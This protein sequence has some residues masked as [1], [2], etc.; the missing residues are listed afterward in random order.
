MF[1]DLF[2]RLRA[3]F[4]RRAVESDLDRELRF[5]I[6]C[7]TEKYIQAGM[8][9]EEAARRA[10]LD[11]GGAEQMKEECRSARGVAL[12]ETSMQDLTYGFRQ[13]RRNPGF[14]LIAVA[15]IALGIAAN[16]AVFSVMNAVLFAKPPYSDPDRLLTVWQSYPA[17][18]EVRGGASAAEYL[19]YRN[20]N[21]TF[22][23][24]AGYERQSFDLTGDDQPERV[25]AARATS[26][27]FDTLGIVP[28]VGRT[29]TEAEDRADAASVVVISDGFWHRYYNGGQAALGSTLKLNERVYTVI[30]VMPR[31]FEFPNSNTTIDEAPA[32]WIPMAFPAQEIAD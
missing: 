5:H 8:T 23:S 18:G 7:Q 13:L 19:D 9:S 4:R 27:L 24:L 14:T 25:S 15:T 21:S 30:G 17:M 11:F 29:F 6:E 12:I 3:I 2:Y 20:R 10:R 1:A 26:N 16:T 32:L 28:Q 22:Q 31:G